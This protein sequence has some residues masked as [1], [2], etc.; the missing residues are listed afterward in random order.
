MIPT[1]FTKYKPE[2]FSKGKRSIIY[3]FKK[4]NKKYIIKTKKSGIAAKDPLKNE[5]KFLKIL[6]KHKIG[7]K[8]MTSGKNYVVYKFVKG[9]FFVDYLETSKNPKIIKDI[10]KQ[11]RTLD[12]LK[13]NKKEMHH[14]IKHI[15]IDKK[16]VMIDFERC[17]Y[18]KKPKN[19]TQFCQF[20]LVKKLV[21]KTLIKTLKEYKNNE[22]DENFKKILKLI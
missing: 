21:K 19:V 16:P 12:K 18:T 8:Y 2:Y 7:P 13:I 3:L 5:A 11:C 15:I 10:L 20:L 4:N 6:N 1:K 22:S 17:Y 9:K 14:P